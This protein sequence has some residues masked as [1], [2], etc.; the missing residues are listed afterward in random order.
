MLER[1]GSWSARRRRL[2][3]VVWTILAGGLI[4]LASLGVGGGT[5]FDRLETSL[6]R[7]PGSNSQR[8]DDLLKVHNPQ[9]AQ[10]GLLLRG[11]S[12]TDARLEAPLT[13]ATE[14]IADMPHVDRVLSVYSTGD[15]TSPLVK[16]LISTAGSGMAVA[17][18]FTPGLDVDLSKSATLAVAARLDDLAREVRSVVPESTA[19]VGGGPLI[20]TEIAAQVEADLKQGELVALPLSLLIMVIV[21]CGFLAAT[22]PMIG[23]GAAICVALGM[24]FGM[25]YLLKLDSSV[26]NI[27]SILGL[28]L[29]IDYG[30][31]MVSRFREELRQAGEGGAVLGR[32]EVDAAVARCS[33]TAGRTIVFSGL[34]IAIAVSSLLIFNVDFIRALGVASVA[35]T[36]IAILVSITLVPALLASF[37]MRLRRPS[38]LSRVPGLGRALTAFGDVAPNTGFFSRLAVRIQRLPGLIA[39]LVL[40]L[41]AFLGTPALNLQPQNS[42]LNLLP[43]DSNARQ[44]V[45]ILNAEYPAITTPDLYFGVPENDTELEALIE[46]R[47]EIESATEPVSEGG[48]HL[49][50]VTLVDSAN[51]PLASRELVLEL[52]ALDPDLLVSGASAQQLDFVEAV[53]GSTPL[54][55][56]VV[57]LATF[58]V[59]F[60]MTGSVVIPL[61]A[62][63]MNLASLAATFGL[64][65]WIFQAGH[66]EGWLGF[67]S[68][69]GV[70]TIVI[71]LTFAMGFGLSMDYEVFL[72]SR[73]LEAREQGASDAEAVQQGLQRSGRIITSAAVIVVVV[74][75]GFSTGELLVV[76]QIGIG[77][78]AAVIIDATLV[79]CLLVPATM[80]MLGRANWW[81]PRVLKK[82]YARFG[83]RD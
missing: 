29:S 37:G 74:F 75:L 72:L 8:L 54:A 19:L 22:V 2:V 17:V 43:R 62:L 15:P 21:F 71:V 77:L 3:I 40:I 67:T 35:V 23:A 46:A 41:L 5:V 55:V 20:G 12:P 61:K 34:T 33:A 64:L 58:V 59:L 45:A 11:V 1:L 78:A 76:K 30:L 66:L 38:A 14:A 25:S 42:T 50:A 82:V 26:V 31:L 4:A 47:P 81:S 56:G 28:G 63:V 80:S 6:P 13:Q 65:T 36:I 68:N 73:I 79:R 16:P 7:V 49:F 83:L 32:A 9:A 39:V 18:Q 27:V 57:L 51:S 24:V 44:F 10:V 52:R 53:K 70:E 69:G 48:Y 60:L